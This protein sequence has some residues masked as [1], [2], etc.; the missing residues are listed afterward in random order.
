MRKTANDVNEL[1]FNY[2]GKYLRLGKFIK[3]KILPYFKN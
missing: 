2:F 1:N 3:A